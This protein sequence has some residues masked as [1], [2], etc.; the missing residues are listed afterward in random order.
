MGLGTVVVT[1]GAR[2]IGLEV[3]KQ[4]N[5][6]GWDVILTARDAK[7]AEAAANSLGCKSGELDV[8]D[9]SSI[10][11]F[12]KRLRDDNVKVHTLVNNAGVFHE[13]ECQEEGKL[14]QMFTLSKDG[15]IRLSENEDE[16]NNEIEKIVRTNSLG[17]LYVTLAMRDLMARRGQIVMVSSKMATMCT[18]Q[19]VRGAYHAI[20]KAFLNMLTRQFAIAFKPHEVCVNAVHP[21]RVKTDIGGPSADRTPEKGAETIVWVAT[22]GAGDTSG[23]FFFDKAEISW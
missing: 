1:G 8:T 17:P 11:R 4:L 20:S 6:L 23:K 18:E 2:G 19:E 14:R 16:I 3:C 7:R 15:S 9:R 21:G 10:E 22:G 13:W 12:A 5:K